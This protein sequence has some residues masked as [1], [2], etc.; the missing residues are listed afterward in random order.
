MATVAERLRENT[1]EAVGVATFV[2]GE[3][4]LGDL[5]KAQAALQKA[6]QS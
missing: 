3:C 2:T 5:R 6:E 1:C 4:L